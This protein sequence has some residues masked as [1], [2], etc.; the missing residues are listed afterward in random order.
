[1][2]VFSV[3]FRYPW[4]LSSPLSWRFANLLILALFVSPVVGGEYVVRNW[5]TADG[6]PDSIVR[7]VVQTPD[8]YLWVGTN[9]GIARF[10]GLKFEVFDTVNTPTLQSN[11]VWDM[12]VD[13]R[14]I[15]CVKY[16]NA[17]W[18]PL[19]LNPDKTF[20]I[21]KTF[22]LQGDKLIQVKIEEGDDTTVVDFTLEVIAPLMP[23]NT[24]LEVSGSNT[25]EGRSFGVTGDFFH[26]D[27]TLGTDFFVDFGDRTVVNVGNQ[28]FGVPNDRYQYLANHNTYADDGNYEI[29]SY[30][31]DVPTRS[32]RRQ[33]LN[34]PPSIGFPSD[35]TI[36]EGEAISASF[37]IT[38]Q[39][40]DTFTVA[41]D[42]GDGRFDNLTPAG[43]QFAL[44]K[45]FDRPGTY[46]VALEV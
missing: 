41:V 35:V 45:T 9:G 25:Q 1:M 46:T 32:L 40:T 17:A 44:N 10:D 39:G 3:L 16:N 27:W 22:G 8:G 5:N 36:N 33:V 37:T 38:D 21:G 34:V 6:L 29:S 18:E 11:V 12:L 15:L 23:D 24:K 4:N 20:T 28:I 30:A 7:A 2:V 19:T 31:G 14:G 26:P 43:N 13:Q 42:Y